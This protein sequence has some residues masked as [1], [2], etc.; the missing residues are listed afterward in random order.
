MVGGVKGAERRRQGRGWQ[1]QSPL[2]GK[3]YEAPRMAMSDLDGIAHLYTLTK[4]ME[5]I[6]EES[7]R[8]RISWQ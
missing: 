2:S 8:F 4:S 1:E 7:G 5:L 3:N 6:Y